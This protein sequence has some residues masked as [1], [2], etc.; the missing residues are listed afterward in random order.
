M[1]YSALRAESPE[2]S[3]FAREGLES[4]AL[5]VSM[6][7]DDFRNVRDP[8]TRADPLPPGAVHDSETSTLGPPY[9]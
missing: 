5:R 6:H 1:A 4:M 9:T 3:A 7:R 2:P 8:P